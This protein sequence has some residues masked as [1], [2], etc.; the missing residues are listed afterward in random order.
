MDPLPISEALKMHFPF[1][2]S[3]LAES[4]LVRRLGPQ[5]RRAIATVKEEE[6]NMK[7]AIRMAL[8]GAIGKKKVNAMRP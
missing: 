2:F 4:S 1:N 7:K 5:R 8:H 6:D 3:S